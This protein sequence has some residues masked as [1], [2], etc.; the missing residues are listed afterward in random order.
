M[1]D[2]HFQTQLITEMLS[3]A[4]FLSPL[5]FTHPI[6]FL[7]IQNSLYP[8]KGQVDGSLDKAVVLYAL[9]VTYNHTLHA[10]T[11]HVK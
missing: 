8:S 11:Y 2:I 7:P 5:F 10:A 9:V 1:G 4:E 3:E 6:P